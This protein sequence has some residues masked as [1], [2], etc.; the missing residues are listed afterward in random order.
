M[1]STEPI[2]C[3]LGTD[4]L[5][6]RFDRISELARQHLLAQRREGGAL[7]LLYASAAAPELKEII[8]L[9]Q[10]CCAFLSLNSLIGQK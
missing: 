9:E 4:E 1:N 7:N 2:A 5:K 3:T 10:A 6:A 8:A